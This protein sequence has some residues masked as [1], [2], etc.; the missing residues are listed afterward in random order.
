ENCYYDSLKTP[1]ANV[2]GED[3]TDYT[4][5]KV[6]NCSGKSSSEMIGDGLKNVLNIK[7]WIF[8]KG[9]YPRIKEK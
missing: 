5:E 6:R 2:V 4:E 1:A 9:T 7:F 8:E 3:A